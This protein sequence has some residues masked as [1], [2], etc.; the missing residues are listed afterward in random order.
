MFQ[1]PRSA[2]LAVSKDPNVV[3]SQQE[4]DDIAKGTRNGHVGGSGA[5]PLTADHSAVPYL[6]F[7]IECGTNPFHFMRKMKIP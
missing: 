3:S 1:V 7:N 6:H 4:E 5:D 2:T